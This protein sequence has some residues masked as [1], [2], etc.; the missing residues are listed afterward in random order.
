MAMLIRYSISSPG[1]PLPIF[2]ALFGPSHVISPAAYTE[3]FSLHGTIM[4]FFAVTPISFGALGNY[5]VPLLIGA[6]DMAFPRLNAASFWVQLTATIVLFL[7]AI[8]PS[9]S[10]A[11]GWTGYPPLSTPVGM[12]GRGLTL[13]ALALVLAGVSSTLGSSTCTG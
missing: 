4:I 10:A 3:L 5:L 6:R 7:G 13:W 9:G 1:Q 2:G 8:D 12:P 11:A